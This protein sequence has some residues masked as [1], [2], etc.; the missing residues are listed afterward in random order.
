MLEQ[1]C[2]S[3]LNKAVVDS[4]ELQCAAWAAPIRLVQGFKGK[5]LGF[6]DG[7][8]ADFEAVPMGL[9]LPKRGTGENQKLTFAID[10]VLG[11]AQRAID[12]ALDAGLEVVL[13]FRRY[14]EGDYYGPAERPFRATVKGGG[15][16][17]QTV[18]LD[19]GFNNILDWKWPRDIYDIYEFQDITYL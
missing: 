2:A 3:V 4:L 10:N 6:G 7:T 9:V 16:K 17:G 18:Q 19:A 13:I 14:T 11:E 1:I 15:M 8:Y 12:Q 5:R